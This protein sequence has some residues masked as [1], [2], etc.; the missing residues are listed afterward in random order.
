M[1]QYVTGPIFTPPS[2]A[3][4]GPD[5]KKGT[6]QLPGSV[7]GADWT[8][9]A[10]DPETGMLYVPSMTNPFV[11]NLLPGEPK[12]DEP[13]LSRLDARAVP[14]PQGLPLHQAAIRPRHGARSESGE[15]RVDRAER[16]RSQ[17]SPRDRAFEVG[18]ARQPG[19]AAR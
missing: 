6:I 4:A 9:A 17:E 14:G 18:A 5:D 8:G 1:K 15:L 19:R 3:G 16:R 10:F 11:A 13:A 12:E 7:G 2:I